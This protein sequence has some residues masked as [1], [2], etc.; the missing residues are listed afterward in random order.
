MPVWGESAN[1]SPVDIVSLQQ[2]PDP[3]PP[4]LVV[5]RARLNVRLR[6]RPL[7]TGIE[8]RFRQLCVGYVDGMFSVAVKMHVFA[9]QDSIVQGTAQYRLFHLWQP[10][11]TA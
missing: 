3:F 7:S 8:A 6:S 10:A 2:G 1:H 4:E 11:W 9:V 5:L